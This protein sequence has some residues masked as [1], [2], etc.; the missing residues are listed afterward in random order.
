V[1]TASDVAWGCHA[2]AQQKHAP[3]DT[4]HTFATAR[5]HGTLRSEMVFEED[6]VAA[7]EEILFRVKARPATSDK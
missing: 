5:K 4:D 7:R 6:G 2:F 3:E 1:A